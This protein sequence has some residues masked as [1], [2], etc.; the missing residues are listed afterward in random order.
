M[1]TKKTTD[2]KDEKPT[3]G[4]PVERQDKAIKRQLE[5]DATT[6]EN[7]CPQ[8]KVPRAKTSSGERFTVAGGDGCDSS[9]SFDELDNLLVTQ[10]EETPFFVI[11]GE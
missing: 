11:I 10:P 7:E 3:V 4:H 5:P 1:P 2:R 8:R 6:K 9:K